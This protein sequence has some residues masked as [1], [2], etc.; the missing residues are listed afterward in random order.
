MIE[1][2]RNGIVGMMGEYIEAKLSPKDIMHLAV[3]VL[4]VELAF[5]V[6]DFTFSTPPAKE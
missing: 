1:K 4:C 6:Y 2:L 3:A 5:A